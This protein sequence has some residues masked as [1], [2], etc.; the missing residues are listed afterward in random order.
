MTSIAAECDPSN[1]VYRSAARNLWTGVICSSAGEVTCL[2]L[3]G[4][5]FKGSA[6]KSLEIL[7][8][9]PSLVYL[10]L[11]YNSL[12]G[13]PERRFQSGMIL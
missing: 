10:N 8:D 6:N 5:G 9:L 2:H 1:Q 7:K 3:A 12:Y 11:Q 4:L 13:K